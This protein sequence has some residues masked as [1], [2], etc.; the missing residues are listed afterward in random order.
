[1]TRLARANLLLFALLAAHTLDHAVNQPARDLPPTGGVVG[2]LGFLIVAGSAWLA[3]R[4]SDRA[5]LAGVL[6]GSLTALGFVAVHLLPSWSH[7]ISDPYW[8]F[9]ANPLSWVLLLAPLAAAV[10]LTAIAAQQ[11]GRSPHPA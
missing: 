3:V 10:A 9:S 6:A 7:A 8:D 1:M 2:L 5:A 4:R 11:L